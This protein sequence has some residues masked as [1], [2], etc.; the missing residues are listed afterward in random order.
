MSAFEV[1]ASGVGGG[2]GIFTL[3]DIAEGDFV[4]IEESV[5][6][7]FISP[8]THEILF[9]Q[10]LKYVGQYAIF[11]PTLAR[12]Y[13]NGYGMQDSFFVSIFSFLFWERPLH[14]VL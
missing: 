13:I 4:G 14:F 12:G 7:M 5:H 6:G 11:L 8:M 9:H 2:R 3:E 1:K 10:A